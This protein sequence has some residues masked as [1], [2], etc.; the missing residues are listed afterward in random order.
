MTFR[1]WF[2]WRKVIVGFFDLPCFMKKLVKVFVLVTIA[3]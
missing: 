1:Y 2:W 3:E